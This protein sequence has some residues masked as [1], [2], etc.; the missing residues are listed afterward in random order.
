VF[1]G[2]AAEDALLVNNV[3]GTAASCLATAGVVVDG[4]EAV[5]GALAAG[6][7]AVAVTAA[8]LDAKMFVSPKRPFLGAGAAAAAV[9]P[10]EAVEAD[11]ALAEN[12]PFEA[13][14]AIDLL[15]ALIGIGRGF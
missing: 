14:L 2:G 7:A 4:A 11:A 6:A 12:E 3:C 15:A 10:A 5:T 9:E 13:A 8:F 1:D